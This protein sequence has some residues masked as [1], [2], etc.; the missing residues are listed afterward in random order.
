MGV[1]SRSPALEFEQVVRVGRVRRDGAL[2]R[3][4]RVSFPIHKVVDLLHTLVESIRVLVP[5]QVL[6]YLLEGLLFRFR[7]VEG[8]AP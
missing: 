1:D 8:F 4:Q 6:F 2:G 5:H 3:G 7:N